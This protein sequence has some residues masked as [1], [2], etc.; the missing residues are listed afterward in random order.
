MQK[1]RV[2]YQDLH[3]IAI[4][5]PAGVLVHPPEDSERGLLPR[6][7]DVI[8]MLRHQ[9]N[10]RVFPV[11][12]LDRATSGVLLLALNPGTARALQGQFQANEIKKTYLLLVRGWCDDFGK[13]NAPLTS[14]L[15][16]G[17]LRPS[18]TEYETIFRIEL[19]FASQKF[20]TSRFSLVSAEPKTGRLHQIRRHFKK[21]NHPLIGDTVHGDGQ[22]NRIWRDLTQDKMLY[23][24]AYRLKLLHPV[25][26]T[27][28]NL[29][30]RFSG[31]WHRMF[32]QIG[33]CPLL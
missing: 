8:R 30:S 27:E 7:P 28:L 13:I 5:K 32:D 14:N 4:D 3:L 23:L 19:P 31:S 26:G 1:L 21:M 22:Q 15:K 29:H 18:L 25:T 20:S 17:P 2:I 11:H 24:K 6:S 9:L 33:F 10:Q 12:R 16:E